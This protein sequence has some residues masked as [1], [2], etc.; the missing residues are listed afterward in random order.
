MITNSKI[1]PQVYYG[2]HFVAGIAEYRPPN[3]EMFRVLVE[4]E[5]IRKMNPS[6][7]GRPVYVHHVDEVNLDNIQAEADGYVTESFFNKADGKHWAKFLVVSDKG[8]EAIRGGWKLSNAYI[9]KGYGGG[10]QRNGVDYDKEITSGEFEHLAIVPDPRY[11]ESII[12]TPDQFKEYNSKKEAELNKLANSKSQG[13]T[14]MKFN[15]FKKEKVENGIDL[16]SMSVVLPSSKVEKTITQLINE[17]DAKE[18]KK[19]L[20][21]GEDKGRHCIILADQFRWD[22]ILC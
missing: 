8:H 12:F 4:D 11:D 9:I 5:T 15:F 13:V 22:E 2:L 18:E 10:G 6:F 1:I 14:K 3:E 7:A 19:G 17:A 20:A 21:N 16:E